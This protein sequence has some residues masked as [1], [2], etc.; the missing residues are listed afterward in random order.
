M[1]KIKNKEQFS[2]V[3]LW[4]LSGRL[5]DEDKRTIEAMDDIA[6]VSENDIIDIKKLINAKPYSTELGDYQVL[7]LKQII[8]RNAIGL[9]YEEKLDEAI[10]SR[11]LRIENRQL[12]R[13]E[14]AVN[15]LEKEREDKEREAKRKEQFEREYEELRR[16]EEEL[17]AKERNITEKLNALKR[18]DHHN[19]YYIRNLDKAELLRNL[20]NVADIVPTAHC[21]FDRGI[22]NEEIS[23][24]QARGKLEENNYYIDCLYGKCIKIDFRGDYIDVNRFIDENLNVDPKEIIFKVR[25]AYCEE[26]FS[27]VTF[28][29]VSRQLCR[30]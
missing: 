12:E 30:R 21:F 29:R 25:R 16:K 22:L 5:S 4:Y 11:L 13:R 24:E 6:G 1:K 23:T 9:E 28:E 27:K 10:R 26:L 20:I 17:R 8:Q 2:R 7:I 14:A 18:Q 3:C 15:R 19:E